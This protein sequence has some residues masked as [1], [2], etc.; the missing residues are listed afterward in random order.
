[1]EAMMMIIIHGGL[2]STDSYF[3]DNICGGIQ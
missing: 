3:E 2:L 1:M